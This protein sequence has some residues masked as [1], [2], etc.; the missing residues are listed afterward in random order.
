MSVFGA[1][2]ASFRHSLPQPLDL[3]RSNLG[4]ARLQGLVKD[5]LGGDPTGKRFDL[6]N[7]MF[8]LSYVSSPI[9]EVVIKTYIVS[10]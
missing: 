9:C 10:G 7:S 1:L 8:F 4:N 2:Y 3:D 6:V 5:V